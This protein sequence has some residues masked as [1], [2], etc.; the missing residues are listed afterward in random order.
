[1]V[2]FEF[3]NVGAISTADEY[4]GRGIEVRTCFFCSKF[5]FIQISFLKRLLE[6]LLMLQ[7]YLL[8]ELNSLFQGQL[9]F[10]IKLPV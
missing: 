6:M 9:M 4:G 7:D 5:Y 8:V 1:M 3:D 10:Q 2:Y